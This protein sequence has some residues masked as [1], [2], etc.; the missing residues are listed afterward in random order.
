MYHKTRA[1]QTCSRTFDSSDCS[2]IYSI[3]LFL[4]FRNIK[5]NNARKQHH[6][7]QYYDKQ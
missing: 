3:E 2:S 1:M 6:L 4:L 7:P 5:N